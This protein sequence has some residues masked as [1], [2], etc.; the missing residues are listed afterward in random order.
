MIDQRTRYQA[1]VEKLLH[2]PNRVEPA[3]VRE[4]ERIMHRPRV[5]QYI[6]AA[7]RV[8]MGWIF[9]W[10]FLDKLFGLG[11]ATERGEGWLAGTSPTFGFLEFGTKGPFAE[12]Y[13]SIAGN[14]FVDWVFMLGLL[15]IGVALVL[16]IGV[17][18]AAVSGTLML[19]LMWTAAIWPVHN[20]FLDD[21]I[22]YGAVLIG[23][24]LTGAGRY[25]GLGNWWRKTRLV[26]H[27]RFL[28]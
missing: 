27:Y 2:E 10:P 16:G 17:R 18:I 21:H 11:F 26:R 19:L 24:A 1:E 23:V 8:M 12:A 25:V 3:P 20:P 5:D 15:G 22:I 14:A 28:E 13:Q 6:W 4:A 7:L 9:L